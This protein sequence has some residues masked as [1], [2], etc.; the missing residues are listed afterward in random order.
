MQAQGY[1]EETAHRSLANLK[2]TYKWWIKKNK[3]IV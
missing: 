1:Q 2:T 3:N